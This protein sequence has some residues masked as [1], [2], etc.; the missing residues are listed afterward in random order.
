M[1]TFLR[2]QHQSLSRQYASHYQK[3]TRII[4]LLTLVT[5]ANSPSL[6]FADGDPL[7]KPSST[8]A[9]EHL[10]QGNKL[11]RVREFEKAIEEYKAGAITDD[12][13]V[14]AYN[15]GQ[16]YRQLGKYEDAIWHYERFL[17]R[18]NPSGEFRVSVE[19]FVTQ[20][21]NEREHKAMSQPPTEPAPAASLPTASIVSLPTKS[22]A[23]T[24][25]WSA[26]LIG[27]GMFGGGILAG[28]IGGYFL[29]NASDL[30][31]QA[32]AEP[33]SDVRAL[34]RDKADSR[35]TVGLITSVAGLGLLTAGL[36]KLALYDHAPTTTAWRIMPNGNGLAV[37]GSF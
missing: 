7:A 5:F 18:A 33:R 8:I 12:A 28:G 19:S 15:L 24:E 9:R 2:V 21:K 35:Q 37:F 1:L 30:N 29:L 14:F 27:W 11:Y 13:P 34:L 16:C 17:S 3:R 25:P 26:D 23:S 32:N 20:M 6:V 31:D 36:V 4:L 10:S 22:M